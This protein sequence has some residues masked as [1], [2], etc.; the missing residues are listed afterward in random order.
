MMLPSCPSMDLA[1]DQVLRSVWSHPENDQRPAVL[2]WLKAVLP[3]GE[4]LIDIGSG[5]AYYMSDAQPSTYTAVEP[6]AAMRLLTSSSAARHQIAAVVYSTIEQLLAT[7]KIEDCTTVLM[8]HSLFYLSEDEASQLLRRVRNENKRL[9]IVHPDPK[10]ATSV[11]FETSC[12]LHQSNRL[13]DLKLRILGMPTFRTIVP[14]HLVVASDFSVNE[15]A[16]L[17]SHHVRKPTLDLDAANAFVRSHMN[18]WHAGPYLKLPQS[19]IME[20]YGPW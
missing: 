8:I 2:R 13:I 4:A 6:N 12:K 10:D 14:S 5:D 20:V 3:I 16:L 17:V 15:L 9:L 19:Q 7:S 18:A 11:A 1:Y